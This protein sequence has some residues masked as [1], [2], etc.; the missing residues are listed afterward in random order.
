MLNFHI[1]VGA[2]EISLKFSKLFYKF[3]NIFIKNSGSNYQYCFQHI[4][5][6]AYSVT[7]HKRGSDILIYQLF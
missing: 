2:S 3:N 6:A 7:W 5:K 4:L 1:D